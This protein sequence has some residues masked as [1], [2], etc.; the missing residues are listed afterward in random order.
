MHFEGRRFVKQIVDLDGNTFEACK[1]I[2]CTLRFSGEAPTRI[3]RCEITGCILGLDDRALLTVKFLKAMH[4][5]LGNWG[6]N[7]VEEL[8]DKI[9]GPQQGPAASPN[10]RNVLLAERPG[11]E[12]RSRDGGDA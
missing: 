12:S 2:D 6:R 8:F 1:L 11:A 10:R 5:G 9:R 7:C 4:G 3:S